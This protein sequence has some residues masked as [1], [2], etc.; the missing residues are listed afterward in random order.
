MLIKVNYVS[1]QFWVAGLASISVV[2]EL[3]YC[4]QLPISYEI[5]KVSGLSPSIGPMFGVAYGEKNLQVLHQLGTL[6][7]E[8]L[9]TPCACAMS[10]QLR[11][12]RTLAFVAQDYN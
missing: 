5:C 8:A 12:F 9:C 11:Y 1:S 4:K 2:R 6:F 3:S 10:I 7:S